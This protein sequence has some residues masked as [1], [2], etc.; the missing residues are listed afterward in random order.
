MIE[1]RGERVKITPWVII[2]RA[3]W[4]LL[5]VVN[6]LADNRVQ[7]IIKLLIEMFNF[8]VFICSPLLCRGNKEIAL[9]KKSFCPSSHFFDWNTKWTHWLPKDSNPSRPLP[10]QTLTSS[11]QE[12]L[13]TGPRPYYKAADNSTAAAKC[14]RAHSSSS[15][16]SNL[17]DLT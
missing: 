5:V 6:Y 16:A 17:T 8:S 3:V 14:P 10:I 15:P 1:V 4:K 13:P 12:S 11:W 2:R 7:K 9:S